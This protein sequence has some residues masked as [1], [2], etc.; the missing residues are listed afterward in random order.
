MPGTSEELE[1]TGAFSLSF[2]ASLRVRAIEE[3]TIRII[4]VVSIFR[5]ITAL[6]LGI[7]QYFIGG[8]FLI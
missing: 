5:A 2:I 7:I 6:C 1:L 8:A 3:I 4:H